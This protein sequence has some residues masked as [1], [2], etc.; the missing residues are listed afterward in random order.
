M[1]ITPLGQYI[2]LPDMAGG[3]LHLNSGEIVSVNVIKE[4]SAS[5]WAI[6]L[7]GTVFR[8]RSEFP[9][10]A[11]STRQAMVVK[12]GARIELKLLA[13]HDQP[14]A[15]LLQKAGWANDPATALIVSNL[16]KSQLK[17]D[18]PT[19]RFLKLVLEKSKGDPKR[20]ARLLGLL[21]AKGI[22][23][24]AG[25]LAALVRL[26]DY[27]A[28]EEKE[29]P[30]GERQKSKQPCP[31]PDEAAAL[32]KQSIRESLSRLPGVLALCNHLVPVNE[33]DNWIIAPYAIDQAAFQLKGTLRFLYDGRN[34]KIKKVV[35]VAY[36]P[37]GARLQ[38]GLLPDNGR[39]RMS[40]YSN[41]SRLIDAPLARWGESLAKLGELGVHCDDNIIDDSVFNGFEQAEDQ[42]IYRGVDTEG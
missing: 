14:L 35:I 25:E 20:N 24:E 26:C 36:S 30:K 23:P 34:K 27:G 18:G 40:V 10:T 1:G 3:K 42:R 8:A 9:L 6:G 19:I 21:A 22:R 37:E 16:M 41:Q 33:G 32:L 39:Y 2:R 5:H 29:R 38:F 12:S 13:E 28:G 17:I 31:T 7:K 15:S 4:L 11:G